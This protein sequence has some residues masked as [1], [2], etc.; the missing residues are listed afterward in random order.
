MWRRVHRAPADYCMGYDEA[1]SFK[2]L[3]IYGEKCCN[4]GRWK[5]STQM[6]EINILQWI[7]S[8]RKKIEEKKHFFRGT[9]DFYLKER[10]KKRHI[11]SHQIID[12]AVL[13]SYCRFSLIPATAPIVMPTN[14]AS[15]EG[16]GTEQAIKQFRQALA[17][18]WRKYGRDFYVITWD[19]HDYFGSIPHEKALNII[20]GRLRDPR[21]IEVLEKY[22]DLFPGGIGYGIGGEPSQV[23]S[24]A[25][26]S[27][28]DRM[29]ACDPNVLGNG[30]Y[31][32]DGWAVVHRIEDARI[33]LEKIKTTVTGK[34]GIA[35]NYKS[36]RIFWME[37]DSVTYLKKRTRLD[38]N[39]KIVMRIVRKN[40]ATRHRL[41]RKQKREYDA[42]NMP[43]EAIE[44]SMQCWLSYSRP[45]Q[46]D[47][48]RWRIAREY[49]ELFDQD[50]NHVKKL[51]RGAK[52]HR[53]AV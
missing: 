22:T 53:K 26:P 30:R 21:D 27:S 13:K 51:M 23:I 8:E 3:L 39:G 9:N 7:G 33:L 18:A 34:L 44:Q 43:F 45:Y 5:T 19:F 25:Y 37:T 6:F 32:D 41:T 12:R 46:S 2:N 4:G 20:G 29:V 31:M 10:G 15:Q 1:M 24:I 49:A 48:A 47:S 14:T 50:W 11:R 35:L 52:K 42:G 40:I 16:K 38:A 17:H 36:T 28:L